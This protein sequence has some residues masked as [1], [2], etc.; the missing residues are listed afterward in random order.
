MNLLHLPLSVGL[1]GLGR[2]LYLDPNLMGRLQRSQN[3]V[4]LSYSR[5]VSSSRFC[6]SHAS[7]PC[8]RSASVL[9]GS[10]ANSLRRRWSRSCRS[11]PC[12][13]PRSPSRVRCCCRV[14]SLTPIQQ[15]KPLRLELPPRPVPELPQH[16]AP[17]QLPPLSLS[18]HRY[19][20]ASC[21]VSFFWRMPRLRYILPLIESCAAAKSEDSGPVDCGC[22]VG[23][24]P[25]DKTTVRDC[26]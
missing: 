18:P 26:P 1:Q 17:P 12:G 9:L 11:K 4:G 7:A 10:N 24:K 5:S 6:R 20:E 25:V 13:V 3:P 21:R 15:M 22:C 8:S 16:A 2:G 19:A 23:R 14:S